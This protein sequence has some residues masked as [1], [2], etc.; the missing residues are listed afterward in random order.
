MRSGD[1][2]IARDPVICAA[3]EMAHQHK[4]ITG[5]SDHWITGFAGELANAWHVIMAVLREIFDESAYERFLVRTH[6]ARSVESYREF[7]QE[8]ESGAAPRPRCC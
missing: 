4:Q 6:S 3:V 8:R 1:P 7:I 5:S 2:V